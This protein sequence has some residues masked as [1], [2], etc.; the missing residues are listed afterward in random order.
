MA[1]VVPGNT[2]S[3]G[4][5]GGRAVG[6]TAPCPALTWTGRALGL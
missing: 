2:T 4:K 3:P 5:L 1:E 6:A